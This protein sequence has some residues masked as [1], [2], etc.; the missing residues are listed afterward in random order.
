ME[1]SMASHPYGP[2]VGEKRK[3]AENSHGNRSKILATL[4]P[5]TYSSSA[6]HTSESLIT[7]NLT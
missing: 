6:S 5:E 4:R 7:I 1:P 3:T 2:K